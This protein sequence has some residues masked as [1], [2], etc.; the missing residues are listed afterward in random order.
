MRG[1]IPSGPESVEHLEGSEQAKQRLRLILETM[2][3]TRRVGAACALL[4]IGEQRFRQL[5]TELLQAALARLEGLPVGRPR[6]PEESA[7]LADLRRQCEE[8][9]RDLQVAQVREEIA[10]ALPRVSVPAPDQAVGPAAA[11]KKKRN[12]RRSPP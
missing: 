8:L 1:R 10:L 4:G 12:Q 3:G 11:N 7:E 9:K 6:Q 5:R 2:T